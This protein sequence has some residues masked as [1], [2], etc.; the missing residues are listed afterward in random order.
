MNNNYISD[1][2]HRID[3]RPTTTHKLNINKVKT[4]E[5]VIKIIDALNIEVTIREGETSEMYEKLKEY[6]D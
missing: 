4:L 5:D 1:L 2:V 6:F 3:L